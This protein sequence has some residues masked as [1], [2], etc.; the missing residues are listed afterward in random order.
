MYSINKTKLASTIVKLITA[1][2]V[3]RTPTFIEPISSGKLRLISHFTPGQSNQLIT[4]QSNRSSA[5]FESAIYN[6]GNLTSKKGHVFYHANSPSIRPTKDTAYYVDYIPSQPS[7]PSAITDR[8][9]RSLPS[10]EF[11]TVDIRD[12]YV[13]VPFRRSNYNRSREQSRA[14]ALQKARNQIHRLE[15]LTLERYYYLVNRL[16][17]VFRFQS[18]TFDNHRFYRTYHTRYPTPMGFRTSPVEFQ[19]KFA[20]HVNQLQRYYYVDDVIYSN[21]DSLERFHHLTIR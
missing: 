3:K 4:I 14:R 13:Q 20:A 1:C 18:S 21:T 6:Y 10:T 15:L 2:R 19:R 12:A 9:S 5:P 7:P 17:S 16:R 11:V 8:L